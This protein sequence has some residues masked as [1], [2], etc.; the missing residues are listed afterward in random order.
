MGDPPRLEEQLS[1]VFAFR[2]ETLR[3]QLFDLFTEPAYFPEMTTGQ[4]CV[5]IGGRGTG[6]TTA[7]RCLSY[8][9]QFALLK[10]D[11]ASLRRLPFIGFYHRINTNRVHALTGP[12]LDS[13]GWRKW[14]AHYVNLLFC[15]QVADFLAWYSSNTGVQI[16]LTAAQFASVSSSLHIPTVSSVSQLQHALTTSRIGFEACIN[17]VADNPDIELSL[18]GAPIDELMQSVTHLD[19]FSNRR[20]FFLLDEYENLSNDQQQ[21]VNTLV[22]HG[23]DTFTFKIG[24][25]EL[26]WRVRTTVDERSEL[27]SPADYARVNIAE[28]LSDSD[29]L[30]FA[31]R[32]CNSRL[33]HIDTGSDASIADVN[34]LLPGMTDDEEAEV[35]G[36]KAIADPIRESLI[37]EGTAPSELDDITSLEM[38]FVNSWADNHDQTLSEA[39]NEHI[40]S[41]TKGKEQFDNYKHALL[42][43]IR[44]GKRGPRKHYSGFRVIA[45]L[46]YKNIR[47]LLELVEESLMLHLRKGSDLQTPVSCA[48]QT[49]A[50]QRV[51]RKN[52]AELEGLSR[53]GADLTKLVL[54]LGRVFGVLARTPEGHTPE[55][56]QFH[57]SDEELSPEV[58]ELL[59]A[60]VTHL[61]VVREP[62]SKL[63]HETDTKAYDYAIH[64]IFTPFFEFSHR[65]KRKLT[66]KGEQ[67]LGLIRTPKRTIKEILEANNRREDEDLP[68]QL[69]LFEKYY[70][71]G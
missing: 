16:E 59:R 50:A 24:V 20:L 38:V 28:E 8:E 26:G 51:G 36:V 12:E 21:V 3:E 55:V 13:A 14:F 27:H 43:T 66:L 49:E 57:L 69:T 35:L 46:A 53:H 34:V 68:R 1:R 9:G 15:E 64:P 60:A 37:L 18:Q 56:T 4:A 41:G 22:K 30:K 48:T 32:V 71:Q 39:F 63:V 54:G 11:V 7:L 52:L 33:S 40:Q 10:R 44:R 6:K 62:G 19:E 5:L 23:G 67:L 17:N 61:A 2:A 31:T 70:E 58:D 45:K 25:R 47:Y 29:F 65:R 42:F